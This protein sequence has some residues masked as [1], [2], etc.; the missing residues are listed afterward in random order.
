MLADPSLS[1]D[2]ERVC[3]VWGVLEKTSS[4][5]EGMLRKKQPLFGDIFMHIHMSALQKLLCYTLRSFLA[6]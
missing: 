6:K 1:T 4:L 2:P 5:V 3:M